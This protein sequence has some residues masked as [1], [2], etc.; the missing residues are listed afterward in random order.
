M[1][2]KSA[3]ADRKPIQ[4][5]SKMIGMNGTTNTVDPRPTGAVRRMFRQD[6]K[7]I[8]GDRKTIRSDSKR[9]R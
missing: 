7:L 8:G 2:R 1:D 4:S 9:N 6:R 5:D 3:H